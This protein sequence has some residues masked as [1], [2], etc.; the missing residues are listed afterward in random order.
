MHRNYV[1]TGKLSTG[2]GRFN[3][4]IFDSRQRG[5][6]QPLVEFEPEQVEQFIENSKGFIEQ[7]RKLINEG[8]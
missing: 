6:Y 2:W 7:M 5:D 1:K 4:I 8:R 3:D